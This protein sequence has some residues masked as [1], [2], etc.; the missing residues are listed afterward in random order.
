MTRALSAYREMENLSS[1]VSPDRSF[2]R[3]APRKSCAFLSEVNMQ[4]GHRS[5]V[6]IAAAP[7]SVED[8]REVQRLAEQ[9]ASEAW[10]KRYLSPLLRPGMRV[11]DVGSDP[12]KLATA[13][14]RLHP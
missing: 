14:A 9:V 6:E 12:D 3:R 5:A 10:V 1:C 13:V 4:F 2:H 8:P 7:Y 11:L